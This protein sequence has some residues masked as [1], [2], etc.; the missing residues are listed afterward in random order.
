MNWT[1]TF[2]GYQSLPTS[3]YVYDFAQTRDYADA[4]AAKWKVFGT[5]DY[6]D[7]FGSESMISGVDRVMY[8]APLPE[9]ET[10]AANIT[11]SRIAAGTFF[12]PVRVLWS[13]L[14]TARPTI[15]AQPD[16]HH[17]SDA[18]NQG[19]ASMMFTLLTGR[20]GIGSEPANAASSE[21]QNWYCRKTGYEI[22]WQY[23]TLQERVPGLEVLPASANATLVT[24]GTSTT[25]TVRFLYPPASDV[26]VAVSIDQPT[27]A[28]VSPGTLT[29]TPQ[30]HHIAQTVTVTGL[31]GT[32]A[33]ENFNVNF[34]T[35]SSDPVFSGLGDAWAYATARPASGVWSA[36]ASG[37]WTD[38]TKWSGGNS[39]N[40]T[41]TADF[42]SIDINAD[43]TVSLDAALSV[44]GL[45][46]GDTAPATTGGWTLDNNGNAANTLTLLGTAPAITV[47]TLGAG[48]SATISTVMAG[49][50]GMSKAGPGTLVLTGFNTYTGGT[51]VN[52]GT[53]QLA[54][55][56]ATGAIRGALT[57]HSGASVISSAASSF[58][59]NSGT[60]IDTLTLNNGSLIHTPAGGTLTLASVGINM[61]GGLMDSTGSAGFDFYD[62][63]GNTSVTTFASPNTAAIAG[64]INLRA[65][66]SDTTGTVFTVADGAALDDLLVSADM[67]NGPYQG[68]ASTIQKSGAGRMVLSG[69]NSY[70]G[71][72]ILNAGTLVASGKTALGGGGTVTF[73]A[74]SGGVLELAT[75]D[76]TL[77]YL[78]NLSMGSNR[79]NTIVVN[80]TAAGDA[81]YALGNFQLGASSMTFNK[82]PELTGNGS[83]SI[84][85]LDLS[86][87]NDGRPVVLNGNATIQVASAAIISNPD[88]SKRL[89]L[90]GTAT[91]NT[92]G[93][94]SN[95]G[96]TG[97]LSLI[98]AGPGT[99]TLVENN[100]Y[101]GDTTISG[102]TLKLAHPSLHDAS[103]VRID[104]TLHL[105][106]TGI[107]VVGTLY[108]GGVLQPA[109]TYNPS[110]SGGFITGTGSL[111]V[112]P[113]ST[114]GDWAQARIT[115]RQPAADFTPNGDPDGDGVSNLAEFAFR[116]NPLDGAENGIIRHSTPGPL[117]LTVAIR[118]GNSAAFTGSPLRLTVAG[119][120]YTIEGSSGLIHFNSAVTEITPAT[121][122]LPDLSTDLDYEYRS[123][124]LGG[125]AGLT[126]SG[127]L[128]AKVEQ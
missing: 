101:S 13:R 41:G 89:Q 98:K 36:N 48:K 92:I 112:G 122:G 44:G 39:A 91:N 25:L 100:T 20:C 40:G 8:A 52:A 28:T 3:G 9:Q 120:T 110:N 38:T 60:K 127:F 76:G 114:L 15:A 93:P 54:A 128:R 81:N 105:A 47:H 58:G 78:H 50:S 109:G 35:T 17:L 72:T 124:S 64:L 59:Y 14:T 96:G 113:G 107:D 86:A 37:T 99:W 57:I 29:F 118:K 66:D 82:G 73:N 11:A 68:A 121:A 18:Y 71:G 125:S 106:H 42:S 87:G 75:A 51:V 6:Q 31:A 85:T 95:G 5:F 23:A 1:Q 16:G 46:F 53:L 94:I 45:T 34:N 108:L 104:G 84:G 24:P 2:S 49:S 103:T 119:V 80:R 56:S 55:G 77:S 88:I 116:G 4:D 19:V 43:R 7:D 102:G 27:A 33:F 115:A 61:T 69:N 65:G 70:S 67:A 63:A 117:V 74:S 12:V 32:I 21:W 123:F 111:R 62:L 97:I 30:N 26:S 90:D 83:L 10:S 126:E 22:A 79:F